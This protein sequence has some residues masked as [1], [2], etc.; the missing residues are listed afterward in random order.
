MVLTRTHV[1]LHTDTALFDLYQSSMAVQ[2]LAYH[3]TKYG[4]SIP[5][6]EFP[7][8]GTVYVVL[9]HVIDSNRLIG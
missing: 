8:L 9:R 1:I 6:M 7:F 2:G 3:Y 4:V 5:N